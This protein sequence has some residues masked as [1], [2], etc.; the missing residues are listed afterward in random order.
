MQSQRI[1]FKIKRKFNVNALKYIIKE[2][3]ISN[4]NLKMK[5]QMFNN[6]NNLISKI[7][8]FYGLSISIDIF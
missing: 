5:V 3:I 8:V 2:I 6:N 7:R 4:V 1:K